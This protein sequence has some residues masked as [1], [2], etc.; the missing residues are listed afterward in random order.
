MQIIKPDIPGMGS[1]L[2]IVTEFIEQINRTAKDSSGDG[3]IAAVIE[4]AI[5]AIAALEGRQNAIVRHLGG[6]FGDAD[7]NPL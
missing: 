6:H 2:P 5:V 3:A 4:A 7:G 1:N